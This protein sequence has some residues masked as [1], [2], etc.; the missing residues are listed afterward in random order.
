MIRKLFIFSALAAILSLACLAGASAFVSYQIGT[1]GWN[2]D[3]IKDQSRIHFGKDTKAVSDTQTTKTL[4]WDGS[5]TLSVNVPANVTFTQGDV[6]SVVITGPQFVIDGVLIENGRLSMRKGFDKSVTTAFNAKWDKTGF[7]MQT[8]DGTIDITIIAPKVSHFNLN[9]SGDL[10]VQAYDQP[11]M[12]VSLAGSGDIRAN[13]HTQSL[14]LNI[15]GSGDADLSDVQATDADIGIA[16]SGNASVH[17]TGKVKAD[18]AGSG[19]VN[20]KGKPASLDSS[21]IGSGNV[22]SDDG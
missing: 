16:G 19:D 22:N 3:V 7:N 8:Y 17:A 5:D 14:K 11:T 15:A 13:G 10:S 12:D 18:I 21:V 20:L 2:W 4:I 6:P 1:T 9:G